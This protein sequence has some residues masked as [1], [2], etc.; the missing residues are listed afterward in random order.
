MCVTL[1]SYT[2]VYYDSTHM[3][4]CVCGCVCVGKDTI[5]LGVTKL[6]YTHLFSPYKNFA[7]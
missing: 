4:V 3:C 5:H 6:S 2:Y 7:L 1:L